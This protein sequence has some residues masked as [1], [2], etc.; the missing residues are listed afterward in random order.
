MGPPKSI[1]D[2]FNNLT[3]ISETTDLNDTI[4]NLSLSESSWR[5]MDNL[6]CSPELL[7]RYWNYRQPCSTKIRT[8]SNTLCDAQD[9]SRNHLS[10]IEYR[11]CCET[12]NCPVEYKIT[13]CSETNRSNVNILKFHN[14]KI[15]ISYN[16]LIGVDAYFKDEIK[17]SI[18][19]GIT[20]PKRIRY[21]LNNNFEGLKLKF[22]EQKEAA[23][24]M[25]KD[26]DKEVK[27][28]IEDG[29]NISLPT[30]RQIKNFVHNQCK[31][32]KPTLSI[33]EIEEYVNMRL[34]NPSE[35]INFIIFGFLLRFQSK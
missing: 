19:L 35:A 25:V 4:K 3:S 32:I 17:I 5:F 12:S 1:D 34:Y 6:P 28:Y 13:T 33:D 7:N 8:N 31:D 26:K 22:S 23:F 20:Q 16:N 27:K 14:H 21:H 2:C 18:Q 10:I 9:C 30:Y 11:K 24:I 29:D 15:Q